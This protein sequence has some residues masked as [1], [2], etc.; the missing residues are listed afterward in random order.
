MTLITVRIHYAGA[1]RDEVTERVVEPGEVVEYQGRRYLIAWCR[2]ARAQRTFR[3]DRIRSI[4][5]LDESTTAVTTVQSIAPD[6]GTR[7][8]IRVHPRSRWLL[9]SFETQDLTPGLA[10]GHD[11]TVM[12]A[13]P[14]WLVRLVLG[15][16]GGVEVV[17]PPEIRARVRSAAEAALAR[18]DSIES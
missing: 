10:G 18:L 7:V 13:D 5:F 9:E 15:Q 14:A 6:R 17:D 16:A 2:E 1:S 3:L 11:A 8:R 12:V 4:A